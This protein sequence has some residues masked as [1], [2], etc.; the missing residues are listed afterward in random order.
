MKS[1]PISK[2]LKLY[3]IL[4]PFLPDKMDKD[5]NF[6]G[7]IIENIKNSSNHRAYIEAVA[8][9]TGREFDQI[10]ILNPGEITSKFIQG[11][12]DNQIWRLKEFCTKVGIHA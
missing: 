7:T 12:G 4:S 5:F 3:E 1:L 10:V 6:V 2:A 9:M 11:L 8:L